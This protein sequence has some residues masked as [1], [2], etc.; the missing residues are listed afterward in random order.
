MAL[1]DN[2]K[3]AG[4]EIERLNDLGTEFSNVYGDIGKKLKDLAKSSDD[5][6]GGIKD[7]VKLS[8]NLAQSA[9]ELAK[10]TLDDLKD[11]KKSNDFIKKANILS[12]RRSQLD[13]QIRVFREQSKN[14][15]AEEQAILNKVNGHLQN[16]VAYSNQISKGFKEINDTSE[17]IEKSNPFNPLADIVG[18][19]PV[20]RK[21]FSEFEKSSDAFRKSM[22]D[23]EGR[24][25]SIGEGLK[26]LGSTIAKLTAGLAVKGL[27]DFDERSVSIARNFNTSREQANQ[28]VKSANEA[29]RSIA[30]V[31]GAD[32]SAAQKE[33]SDALGTTAVLSNETAANFSIL[34]NKLG[35]SATEASELTKFS[36]ALGQNSKTQTEELIAQTQI[37]NA[38][39]DSSIRYQDVLKDV[40][41]ANKA[42]LLSSRGN[43]EEL[44]R[45][46]FEAKKF[47]I[48]LNQADN[49][50]GSLLNFESSIAS[51]LEAE[52]LTGKQLNLERARQA[53]LEGDLATLTS[54]IAKNVGSA[55]EFGRMNR[56]QQEAIAKS[57][58]MTREELAA[59]LV[60]Q[61]ALTKLGAKDKNDLRDKVKQRLAEVNAIKDIEEREKAR[62]KLISEL[63]SDELVRQQEN[64]S[65]QELQREAAQKIVEAFDKL[66]VIL[67]PIGKLLGGAADNAGLL[68]NSLMVITGLRF[69]RIGKMFKFFK[70]MAKSS[71]SIAK[72]ISNASKNAS[73]VSKNVTK[74]GSKTAG[75]VAGKG[76]GKMLSKGALKSGI[77]KVPILGALAGIGFAISRFKQGDILGAGLELASGAASIFPGLGTAASVAI[78]AGLAARDISQSKSRSAPQSIAADD[79]TIRTNPKDTLVMAGGTKLGDETNA[80]LRELI[81][82]VKSGGDVYMDGAKVGK[83]IALA[84]SR[85]G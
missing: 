39:T 76:I 51:E 21:L 82:A 68:A 2:L 74:T 50:A 55:E 71:D 80:L 17:K 81:A 22:A 72:N 8:Q 49:I 58:G 10:F 7:A 4:D 66:S 78:D 19:I 75:K 11:R 35:L 85:I 40:S 45:A 63:G 53:A 65:L 5:F 23:G 70:G 79:F 77:K 84:T 31:T 27:K 13:S 56:I 33:F 54:E 60:E 15:T 12:A 30:G 57:V 52:L 25:K 28:L 38:Q 29:A 43:V 67:A 24:L 16:A 46:S 64:R 37:L 61:Q 47:G 34:T 6:G 44:V 48:T 73:S 41:S 42:I 1:D 69:L 83:S 59:S 26:P 3:N 18:E 36:E 9:Q 20:L 62:A 32:I 14:A